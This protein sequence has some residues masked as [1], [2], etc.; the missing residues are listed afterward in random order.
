M[1]SEC[2]R[3]IINTPIIAY[4]IFSS[5]EE[6]EAWQRKYKYGI[7]S[8]MPIPQTW[9]GLDISVFATYTIDTIKGGD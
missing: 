1:G 5:T 3:P 9:S 2:L 8:V 4:K 6:F 7:I